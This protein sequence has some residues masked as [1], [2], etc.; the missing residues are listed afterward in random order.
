MNLVRNKELRGSYFLM[1]FLT[2]TDQNK[3]GL[4]FDKL[5]KDR[6]KEQEPT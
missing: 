6:M 3:I 4:K 2:L 5:M 1:E